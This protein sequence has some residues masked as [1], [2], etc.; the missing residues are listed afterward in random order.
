MQSKNGHHD[1]TAE[2]LPN[3]Q[4]AERA[5]IGGI[6]IDPDAYYEVSDFLTHQHFY[7]H[8]HGDIYKT[9]GDLLKN[10]MSVDVLTVAEACQMRGIDVKGD[11]TL[12]IS[13]FMNAVPT[14]INTMH[15]ARI[16]EAAYVRRSL[17]H[18]GSRIATS[19][20]SETAVSPQRLTEQAE[21]ELFAISD[22]MSLRGVQ[23]VKDIASELFDVTLERRERGGQ[24]AGTP[25]GLVDVD[26]ILRGLQKQRLYILAARPGMGKSVAANEIALGFVDKGRRV[27]V[28]NLEMSAL[29]MSQRMVANLAGLSL[30]KINEGRMNDLEWARFSE[31]TGQLSNMPIYIDDSPTL[32]PS[33]LRAKARRLYAERGIDLIIV[34]YLQLMAA[35]NMT[36]NRVQEISEITRSL[37]ILAK[38]LDIPVLALSQLSRSL[39]ARSDKRPLL[40]DLRDSGSIEQD[41]DCVIFLYRD[42]YYTKEACEV[43]NQSEWIIAKHRNGPIGTALV[44]WNG[45]TMRFRNLKAE[46]INL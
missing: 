28:F 31:F 7:N 25:T 26:R 42:E 10:R 34:D 5:I 6:I 33:Q 38:E 39:E 19:A 27:G 44:Y 22:G 9:M 30:T 14:S 20:L 21:Q 11:M 35:D 29:E 37:K 1:K 4:D 40:S 13:D 23:P 16:V 2:V 43:P 24:L 15:Y 12:F 17:Y 8:I 32:S 36:Y 18:A 46:Q 3:S 41:A 45:D